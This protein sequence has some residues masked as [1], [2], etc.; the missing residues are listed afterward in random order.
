L[1]AL[2]KV[3]RL[4]HKLLSKH[5]A[6]D[7]FDE[8]FRKA[9]HSVQA[10]YG[11]VTL[12]VF[13]ELNYDFLPTYCYNGATNRFIKSNDIA[14]TQPVQRDRAKTE[15]PHFLWGN[16]T[17]NQANGFIYD[18]YK[19]FIG[20]VHFKSIAK[21][22]GY[23]GIAVVLDELLSVVKTLVQGNILELTRTLIRT[24]KPECKLPAYSSTS[25]GILGKVLNNVV[26]V[27]AYPRTRTD[28]F[29]NLRELGNAILF[30]LMIE[31]A[32]SQ[33][34]IQ[35]LLHAAPFQKV[36]QRPVF[37]PGEKTEA[38]QKRFETKYAPLQIV[39]NIESVGTAKQA[40]IAREANLLTKERLCNRGVSIFEVVLQ[41][42][43]GFLDDP[44]WQGN[45]TPGEMIN[46]NECKEFHRL[47]SSLQFVFCMNVW[48]YE[49]K[50]KEAEKVSSFYIEKSNKILGGD[51]GTEQVM[52]LVDITVEQIFGDGL[53]WSGV[54]MMALLGQQKRFECFDFCY[55]I[56]RVQRIDGM[57]ENFKG[58]QLKPMVDR[59]KRFQALNNQIFS[60][61]N[62]YVRK[63]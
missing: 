22:L 19:H 35:D 21:L 40:T 39:P 58:I 41:R 59:I 52:P 54:V 17:L 29:H 31:Q 42:I 61:V 14:F 25:F 26:N 55:H 46:I 8:M 1:E 33:E 27:V 10:P 5:L 44:T 4:T 63:V 51:D 43:K 47:W 57:D 13:W 34:E 20:P 48:N 37:K 50:Y 45:S 23:Q 24:L 49:V 6:L 56:F 16:K 53:V 18:Q 15:A 32:L 9:N 28:L 62:K 36:Q 11:R 7:E 12:H 2:I 30:C 38:R 3:N 60:T